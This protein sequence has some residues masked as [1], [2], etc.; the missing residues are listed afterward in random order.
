MSEIS[1]INIS[2]TPTFIYTCQKSLTSMYLQLLPLYIH[3][4]NLLHQYIY[5]SYL[6]IYMS[7]ISY[8]NIS[9]TPTFIYTGQKSLTSI[10]L[11]LLPLYIHVRNLLHQYN[12][13]SYLYIYMSCHVMSCHS[14]GINYSIAQHTTFFLSVPPSTKPTKKS[15]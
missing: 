2:T 1:Y 6:Y 3:V 10:Y 9:T 14:A 13:N 5:N 15:Y 12:Y 11:Q 4:R 7:E 8:I